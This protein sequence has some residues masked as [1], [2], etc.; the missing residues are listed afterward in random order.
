MSL[1]R[2]ILFIIF[3]SCTTDNTDSKN[4]ENQAYFSLLYLQTAYFPC[5]RNSYNDEFTDPF[6][7]TRLGFL[8]TVPQNLTF[9]D[10]IGGRI[11]NS[12]TTL[13]LSLTFTSLPDFINLN[14]IPN[15]PL[16]LDYQ[17]SFTFYTPDL[18]S[19]GI[20]H[21]STDEP[22]PTRWD[23]FNVQIF[24]DKQQIGSCGK[25]IIQNSNLIFV[26]EKSLSPN[27]NLLNEN[28]EFNAE[29][30]Y[31]DSNFTFQDCY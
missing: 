15:E 26:C 5:G 7:D 2:I 12:T 23:Q 6:G 24:K 22:Q 20:F 4:I 29:L 31:R 16:A 10:L 9:Q 11:N 14:L 30:L 19:V 21:Y 28:T 3:I 8:T 17:A 27:F 1:A 13:T 18:I 25:P